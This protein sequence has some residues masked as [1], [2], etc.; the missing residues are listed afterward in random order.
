MLWRLVIWQSGIF[1]DTTPMMRLFY[2]LRSDTKLQTYWK[3]ALRLNLS[4][5]Y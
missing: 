4:K 1:A 2:Q 3:T 5:N